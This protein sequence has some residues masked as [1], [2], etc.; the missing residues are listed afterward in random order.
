MMNDKQS[1]LE[2]IDKYYNHKLRS[3]DL[4]HIGTTPDT[5]VRYGAERLP[6]IMQQSILTKCIRQHTGN[7]S[8][9]ELT[10]DIIENLPEQIENPIF[11]IQDKSRESIA[12]IT[13][14]QDK[15]GN[16]I[17]IAI[18]LN[19]SKDA[20]KVNS[21]KSIYGKTNLKE[22]LQKHSELEQLHIIDNKKAE[23]LSRLV[24]FQLPQALIASSYNKKI[25]SAEEN[26]N[27]KD[28]LLDRLDKNKNK[29][30]NASKDRLERYQDHQTSR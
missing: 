19:D 21:I 10:R 26:V 17:L 9:H 20:I 28:S 6:L 11:L 8:A 27:N 13:D 3:F 15:N 5:L 7:R 14:T 24:G 29:I 23:M 4:I 18:K 16:N 25:S 22:Y 1:Y 2:Q 12:I 30:S